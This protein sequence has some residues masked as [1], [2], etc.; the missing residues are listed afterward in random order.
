M[1]RVLIDV[2]SVVPYYV[3]GRLSGVSR[4]VMELVQALDR[5]DS[6]PVEISL[7]SQNMKGI[8]G[9]NLATHFHSH[10][11]YLPH[12]ERV[13]RVLKA[14]PVREWLYRYDLMHIPH[15]YELVHRP[16]RCVVT[17]HDAMFFSY[18]ESFLGHEQARAVIPPF[19]RQN[20]AIITCSQNSKKEIVQYMN[21]P[22][23][24]VHVVYW[25][26]DHKLFHPREK[27]SNAYCRNAPFFISS[28]CDV[29]RKNTISLIRAYEQFARDQPEHH[30]ILVWRTPPQE[31]LDLCRNSPPLRGRVH[32]ARNISNEEL[33]QLYS[34]A[35]A[36]FF[37]S[38]YE[39]FGLPILESM[40]AGTPVVT[41]ANSSLPEVGGDAAFYTDPDD[42][43]AMTQHMREFA[44]RNYNEEQLRLA[45]L[46]Q[47]SAFT[48]EKA[49]RETVN[50]YQ[51]CLN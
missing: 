31:V 16:D 46:K 15:N 42:I 8:G 30:L 48:W 26:T 36:T 27:K 7:Y 51:T 33:A 50:V 23:E 29:G 41:C 24:K 28:S 45:S 19:A 18:P 49:A 20:R 38:R 35:T 14:L 2:N 40:A 13:N 25:G 44:N 9:T 39:G 34:D 17:I 1:K 6:L 3:S 12:R 11:L 10:H 32:F 43:D 37:P 22:E 47:A 4:T 21:I 5:L